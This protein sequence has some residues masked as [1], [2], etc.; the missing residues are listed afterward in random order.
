MSFFWFKTSKGWN[1]RYNSTYITP[2]F[3]LIVSIICFIIGGYCWYNDNSFKT[4]WDRVT[5]VVIWEQKINTKSPRG[6]NKIEYRPLIKYTCKWTEVTNYDKGFD[7][8]A[9]YIE[10]ETLTLYCLQR[11]NKI[12][13]RSSIDVEKHI[14]SIFSFILW[15]IFIAIFLWF[16]V[17]KAIKKRN[18]NNGDILKTGF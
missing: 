7:S 4:N 13:T 5:A 16:K 8:S 12:I 17:R 18:K 9:H 15:I 6:Q 10:W 3:T 2:K 11:D 14:S 1:D